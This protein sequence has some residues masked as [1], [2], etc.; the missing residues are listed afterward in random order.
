MSKLGEKHNPNNGHK[1]KKGNC[2][3]EI[4]AYLSPVSFRCYKV[5][6][7]LKSLAMKANKVALK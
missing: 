7:F 6:S 4:H 3:K 2:V 1:S 5:Q